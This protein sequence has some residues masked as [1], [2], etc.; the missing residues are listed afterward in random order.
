MRSWPP[1]PRPH[2]RTAP[3][4]A[5][6][7]LQLVAF[8]EPAGPGS[9]KVSPIR[10]TVARSEV[11]RAPSG[12]RL[13]MVRDSAL[14]REHRDRRLQPEF[15]AGCRSRGCSTIAGGAGRRAARRRR[16]AYARH[17]GRE[18]G[19][20]PAGRFREHTRR[21][22]DGLHDPRRHSGGMALSLD[23]RHNRRDRRTFRRGSRPAALARRS[24]MAQR[25]PENA[26]CDPR[27]FHDPGRGRLG[28]RVPGLRPQP[29]AQPFDAA[30]RRHPGLQ[31]RLHRRARQLSAGVLWILP[32]L[33][34]SAGLR[35]LR[36]A[37]ARCTL[38][39]G[40]HAHLYGHGGDQCPR[41]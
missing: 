26:P 21:D 37:G 22:R 10:G 24:E 31:C 5:T 1:A 12:R 38:S 17:A 6:P 11:R 41:V 2:A 14:I 36:A 13:V 8:P 9:R 33:P 7:D 40:A 27:C 28:W 4:R 3:P 35:H 19:R 23:H 25:R 20:Q 39:V 30:D 29:A 15:R 16:S 34:W 32:R 18:A